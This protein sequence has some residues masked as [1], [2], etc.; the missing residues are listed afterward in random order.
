MKPDSQLSE[1][2]VILKEL[3]HTLLYQGYSLSTLPE[4]TSGGRPPT[5]FGALYPERFCPVGSHMHHRMQTAL[6]VKGTP[7]MRLSVRVRFLQVE[8]PGEAIEREI[9]PRETTIEQLVQ[10]RATCYFVSAPTSPAELKGRVMMQAF[11]V[12]GSNN[13]FLLVVA[14]ENRTIPE[15]SAPVTAETVLKHAFVSTHTILRIRD[16]EFVSNQNP[17]PEWEAAV[18]ECSNERTF[19]ILIGEENRIMLSSPVILYDH[20]RLHGDG[21]S[22]IFDNLESE[23][24]QTP[25]LSLSGEDIP[26]NTLQGED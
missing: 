14:I 6:I 20:P 1:D 7:A 3:V 10:A 21:R 11:P 15:E 25:G 26:S 9:F 4:Q 17:G 23:E 2:E 24:G 8:R 13:G 12:E 19:P 16:G 18:K 22:D 5:P